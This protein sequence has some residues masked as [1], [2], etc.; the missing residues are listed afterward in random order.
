MSWLPFSGT[1]IVLEAGNVVL[2]RDDL[3]DVVSA[4]E[5]SKKTVGKIK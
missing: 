4:I 5:I 1:E 3:M 2:I